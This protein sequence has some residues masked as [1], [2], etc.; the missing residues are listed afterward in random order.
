[1]T[2]KANIKNKISQAKITNLQATIIAM[3]IF[4]SF[5]AILFFNIPILAKIVLVLFLSFSPFFMIKPKSILYFVFLI[6]PSIRVLTKNGIIYQNDDLIL[7]FNAL[8]NVTILLFGGLF[9]IKNRK[10]VKSLFKKNKTFLS[11][12]IFIIVTSFTVLLSTN[13]GNSI[14][15]LFRLITILVLLLFTYLNIKTKKDFNKLLVLIIIGA[16]PPLVIAMHQLIFA[17]TGWWD[18]T[19]MKFR[20]NGTFLHPATL[21]FYLLTTIPILYAIA[22]DKS[23]A[24][25]QST[26]KFLLPFMLFIV[27]ATLA[28]GAWIGLAVMLLIYGILRNR[29]FLIVGITSLF[30]IYL[31]LS[32]ITERVNDIFHP[33]YNSSLK[34]RIRIV[35]TTL[36]AFSQRPVLGYGIGEFETVHLKYNSEAYTYSSKQ[37]HNDYV[38]LLIEIGLIGLFFYLLIYFSIFKTIISKIKNTKNENCE[39]HLTALLVLWI[40]FLVI[41]TGDNVLRT[42]PVQFVLWSYTGGVFALIAMKE[43]CNTKKHNP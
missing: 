41:S 20:I 36:P 42:M 9:L 8:I 17:H 21:A 26:A 2:L 12:L 22:K 32:V 31:S 10:K 1:M 16:I 6:T 39:N 43:S 33:K 25:M 27:V 3:S 14:E 40:G 5:F 19:I 38:R 30:I 4:V 29:K 28:R 24:I 11:F 13:L 35:E 34:T 23:N 15:E 37:A 18:K 7:N